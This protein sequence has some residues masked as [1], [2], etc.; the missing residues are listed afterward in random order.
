MPGQ[1]PSIE[2]LA[3]T[4]R[5]CLKDIP[6]GS[7]TRG[8]KLKDLDGQLCAFQSLLREV[9]VLNGEAR[10]L[11]LELLRNKT[12]LW[13]FVA[14]QATPALG[15]QLDTYAS[16]FAGLLYL[17]VEPLQKGEMTSTDADGILWIIVGLM[18]DDTIFFGSP[19]K[20]A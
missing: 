18:I 20:S 5:Q 3:I 12:N 13:R 15:V 14:P 16:L 2:L 9:S 4:A 7:A 11:K 8:S 1:N 19:I 6:C 10:R 17:V